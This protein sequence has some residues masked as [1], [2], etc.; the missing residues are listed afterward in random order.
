MDIWVQAVIAERGL[1]DSSVAA[2]DLWSDIEVAVD[3]LAGSPPMDDTTHHM[4][5][6]LET[7]ERIALWALAA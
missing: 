1:A 3:H 7:S 5:R 4:L 6:Q 2:E